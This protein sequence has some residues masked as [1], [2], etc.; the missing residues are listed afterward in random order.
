MTTAS[1]ATNVPFREKR[2]LHV[3][4]ALFL[5][6]W[7]W[8]GIN[9]II[10]PDWWLENVLVFPFIGVLIFTYRRFTL[11]QLSYVLIFIY[12][13]MHE[14]GSHYRYALDPI[15]E[16]MKQFQSTQRNHFDRWVHAA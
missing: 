3:L 2:L 12:L 16:W 5:T 1:T 14:W 6:L 7:V 4:C 11:S 8:S 10:V 13:C 15:G 9:P